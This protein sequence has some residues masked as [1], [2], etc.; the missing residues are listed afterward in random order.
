MLWTATDDDASYSS[1]VAATIGGRRSGVFLTRDSLVG[2]DPAIRRGAVPATLA[3]SHR[4]IGQR[5]H[6][7]RRRRPDLRVGAVRAGCRCASRQ[8]LATRG[9][10][11]LRRRALQSLRDERFLQ[12][13]FVRFSRAAGIR[14]ELPRR[15]VPDRDG[16]VEPGT[17][18]RRKRA[19]GRR[20]TSH[21]A[22][23]RRTGSGGGIASGVSSR[24]PARRSCRAWSDLIPHS[25]TDCSTSATRTR[26]LCLDLRK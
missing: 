7:D 10:L 8:R 18:P 5:R 3:R 25:P 13:P 2:L 4:R 17:V 19:S 26:S 20:P 11:D 15:G 16:Q 1:G 21:H 23:R 24:S 12:R 14:P 9:R 6:A 22:R